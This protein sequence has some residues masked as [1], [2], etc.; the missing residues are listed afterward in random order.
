M[1][2]IGKLSVVIGILGLVVGV[3]SRYFRE[4]IQGIEAHA[5]V[6]FSQACFL[7]GIAAF[8]WVREET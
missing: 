4:P 3:L 1:R 6:S 7:L 8:L 2:G 5:I